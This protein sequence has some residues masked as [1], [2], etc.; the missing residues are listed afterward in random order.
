MDLRAIIENLNDIGFYSVF[1]PFILIYVI[2]YAILE[3]SGIFSKNNNDDA[4]QTKNINS[5]IAFVFGLFVVASI[6]TVMY[7]QSLIMGVIVFIIFVLVI[8]IML[9][10]IFGE[11]YKELFK[12]KYVK[13]GVFAIVIIVVLGLLLYIL[14]LF[15]WISSLDFGV[16]DDDLYSVFVLLLIGGIIFWVSKNDGNGENK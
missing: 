8:L 14:G 2:V 7:I 13:W 16:E 4:A 3:K 10:F 11:E 1:L 6:N 12:N 5:I 9:G 15:D